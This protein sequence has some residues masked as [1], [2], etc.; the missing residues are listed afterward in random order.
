MKIK[1]IGGEQGLIQMIKRRPRNRAVLVGIGDDAAVV[2]PGRKKLVLTTDL[3]VEDDHF[4]LKWSSPEQVGKKAVEANVSDVA[5][6]NAKPLYALVSVCLKKSATVEF[7]RGLY[8]GIYSAGK[9]YG[10]DVI[11]GDFTHGEK[12]VVNIAMVGE[13]SG[14]LCLRSNAKNGDLIFVSGNIGGSTAGLEL[15]RKGK[16]GFANVKKMHLEPKAQLGKALKI[17]SIANAMED[18]S[19]G[20][21]SEVKNICRESGKGA[22]IFLEKI[23]ISGEVKKAAKVLEKS[24]V[25]FALFG[26][27]DFELVF[28]V[29]RKNR[30]RA[31]RLGTEVGKITKGKKIYLVENGKKAL[32]EKAGYDHFA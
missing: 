25:D 26:G 32:L 23:P 5:A 2:R 16:R 31:E 12:A 19:D 14:R 11:G 3:L 13:A 18:V 9:K 6:M 24:A 22:E 7:V 1:S 20:L 15:L 21:A 8:K 30:K 28:T 17:G 29:P 27:E 4:S 10:V